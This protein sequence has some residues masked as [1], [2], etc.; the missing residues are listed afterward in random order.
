MTFGLDLVLI[1][2]IGI[3]G[4]AIG[5]ASGIVATNLLAV[6]QVGIS[7]KIHPFGRPALLAG[8]SRSHA[9]ADW[10]SCPG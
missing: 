8:S 2:R 7:L 6:L 1:P 4:A 9:M 10:R 3:L 5:W